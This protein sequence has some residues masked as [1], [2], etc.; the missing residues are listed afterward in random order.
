ML[1]TVNLNSLKVK[2][3]G[4]YRVGG[5][6]CSFPTVSMSRFGGR[7]K[8]VAVKV[9]LSKTQERGRINLRASIFSSLCIEGLV[10]DSTLHFLRTRCNDF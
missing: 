1:L 9:V 8:G 7:D 2:R 10:V 5:C 3:D 4:L 6:V